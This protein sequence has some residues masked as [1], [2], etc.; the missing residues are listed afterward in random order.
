MEDKTCKRRYS[1][2]RA[3]KMVWKMPRKM[4]VL[5][6][7]SALLFASL[8]TRWYGTGGAGQQLDLSGGQ[9]AEALAYLEKDSSGVTLVR[10]GQLQKAWLAP[11]RG[12]YKVNVG[13]YLDENPWLA[14]VSF[15]DGGVPTEASVR[16]WSG[17]LF[18][19]YLRNIAFA[20]FILWVLAAFVAPHVFGV[21]CPD[22][23]HSLISPALTQVQEFTVY[24]GGVDAS[25]YELAPIIRRDYVCP[26]CGYR[27]VTY[28]AESQHSGGFSAAGIPGLG[29][30]SRAVLMLNPKELA[31]Y[32]KVMEK[33][34]D[35][36]G[37]KARFR[38]HEDW[39]AF[40]DEMKASE[41]EE[42]GGVA[43]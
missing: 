5:A 28:F 9:V 3:W 10:S 27:K 18:S 1:A 34:F 8:V 21:K 42:R 32:D 43:S 14:S 31:W 24:P 37:K 39:R 40:Y 19:T 7:A 25:G 6:F 2:R 16:L 23:P 35:D 38:T 12:G 26:R 30:P 29:R 36:H 33:W 41:R 22:C 15:D 20:F 4:G 11:A 13:V 17:V